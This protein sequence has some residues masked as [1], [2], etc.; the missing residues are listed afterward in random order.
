MDRLVKP[1]LNFQQSDARIPFAALSP[2]ALENKLM[3]EYTLDPKYSN[4]V[5]NN[6]H[7]ITR[8]GRFFKLNTSDLRTLSP[9]SVLDLGCGTT[10]ENMDLEIPMDGYYTD[11]REWE[12]HFCRAFAIIGAKVVGVDYHLNTGEIFEHK[13]KNLLDGCSAFYEFADNSFDIIVSQRLIELYPA[14]SF[15]PNNREQA[16]QAMSHSHRV[17]IEF[18][19]EQYIAGTDSPLLEKLLKYT[20]SSLKSLMDGFVREGTRIL[21]EGGLYCLPSDGVL[22]SDDVFTKKDGKLIRAKLP[23]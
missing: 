23:E 19:G 2:K 22:I 6:I 5:Q 11:S 1:A 13:R 4:V 10:M 16:E 21:K 9:L 17:V 3:Q 14:A 18:A 7:L 12:P 20:Y 15:Y 8:I